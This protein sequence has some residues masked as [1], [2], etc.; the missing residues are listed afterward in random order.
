ME[1]LKH[2]HGV[3]I[4]WR[5]YELRPPGAPPVPP[6]Y[7]ARIEAGRPRL[8]AIA[9]DQYGLALNVGPFGIDSRPA[10]IGAKFAEEQGVGEAYH[11]AVFRAYWLEA[12]DIS[13]L[14]VLAEAATAVSLDPNEFLAALTNPHYQAEMQADVE[15]AYAY[16]LSGVPA[17]VYNNKYLVSGAQ[18]YEVLAEVAE[19]AQADND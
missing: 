1:K 8:Y 13:E 18:P 16:G 14:A 11:D 12:K 17:L 7:R 5:S 6:E 3:T 2:S 15:Q 10:L 4:Q 19:K 9:Q